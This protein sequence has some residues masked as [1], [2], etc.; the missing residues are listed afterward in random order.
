MPDQVRQDDELA[1]FT[2]DILAGREPSVSP[3]LQPLA[4]V[5]RQLQAVIAPHDTPDRV[6]KQHLTQQ[7]HIVWGMQHRRPRWLHSRRIQ[8]FASLLA[9]GIV[10]VLAAVLVAVFSGSGAKPLA[11]T[12]TGSFAVPVLVVIIAAAITGLVVVFRRRR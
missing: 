5:V 11:G 6:F 10:L 2:D 4:D 7:L 3:E 1:R 9:A 12:S 8:R